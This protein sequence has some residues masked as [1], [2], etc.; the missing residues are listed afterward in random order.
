VVRLY[1][2]TGTIDLP[3]IRGQDPP[4][5]TN[6][7]RAVIVDPDGTVR[8]AVGRRAWATC[9]VQTPSR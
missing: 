6:G 9:E 5:Y 1:T 8:H 7:L 4:Y 3:R 2:V